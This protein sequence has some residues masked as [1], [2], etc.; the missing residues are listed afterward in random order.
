MLKNSTGG[1]ILRYLAIVFLATA[2][3][4]QTQYEIGADIGYGIYHD[5][6]IF[7]PQ[8]T[9]QAG[10]LNRFAAG[11][12]FGDEFSDYVS[13][14]LQYLYHD[15]HPFLNYGGTRT[16]IQGNSNA[17]TYNFLFHFKKLDARWRPFLEGGMGAKEY[18]IAGPAPNPQPA[19]QIATLTTNDVWKVV[20]V[21]GAGIKFHVIRQ[22]DVRVEFRDYLTT[23][24]RTQIVPAAGNTARGIFQQF[25]PLFGIAYTFP[26]GH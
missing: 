21:P 12:V 18:V 22:M 7:S 11:I 25:T 5:G 19:P 6:T 1:P 9:A 20:F 14:E 16:D 4:A 10:I 23:F 24:P 15:G 2:A 8:G 13:A 3:W 26:L 17:L